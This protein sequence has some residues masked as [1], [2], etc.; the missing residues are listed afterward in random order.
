MSYNPSFICKLWTFHVRSMF[1]MFSRSLMFN[2][3]SRS[4]TV[5]HVFTFTHCSTC[6]HVR[7]LFKMFSRSL[8]VQHVF[9][10]AHCSTSFHVRSLFNTFS[11]S[12]TV[13]HVFT[14]AH[15][16]TCLGP[17]C[18]NTN[19]FSNRLAHFTI[20]VIDKGK[21]F[22]SVNPELWSPQRICK[23]FSLHSK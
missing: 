11:R 3:F 17:V 21:G 14:F 7:S 22:Y 20:Y 12:L 19:C 13:Q 16:S 15:C 4:L 9:T 6:F 2:I 23:I 8:T 18:D 1:N 10:F 5:Q